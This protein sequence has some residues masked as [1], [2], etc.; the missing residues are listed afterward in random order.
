MRILEGTIF[1]L[2][3]VAIAAFI[4]FAT[5]ASQNNNTVHGCVD[6]KVAELQRGEIVAGWHGECTGLTDEQYAQVDEQV[7][8]RL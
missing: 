2:G 5:Q 3:A 7:A 1:W 8:A 4:V 6:Q